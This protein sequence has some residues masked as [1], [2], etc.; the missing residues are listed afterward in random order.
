ML[1]D[2]RKKHS[3]MM[4]RVKDFFDDNVVYKSPSTVATLILVIIS[5]L[6]M[7]LIGGM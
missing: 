6:V 2:L 1:G 3:G 7:I 4:D 5:I